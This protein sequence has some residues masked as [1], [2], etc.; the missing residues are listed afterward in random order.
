MTAQPYRRESQILKVSTDLGLIFGFAIVCKQGG[1]EYFDVQDDNATE[2]G[3]LEAATDFAR[4]S[5]VACIMHARE[6]GQP[7]PAGAVV[8]TFPLTTEI[9]KALGITTERT[10]LLI[11]MAP[12][13]PEIL[14]KA[15][16]G[17]FTGFSIGGERI[18]DELVDEAPR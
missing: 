10:G 7:V 18:T 12:D 9:A 5:R 4:N 17:E 16:R 6:K 15:R 14:E 11:A 13:D 8:H 3:M 2:Q 1:D